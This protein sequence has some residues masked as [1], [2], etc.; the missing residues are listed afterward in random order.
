M[1]G[2]SGEE[3]T[4]PFRS[5]FRLSQ[6]SRGRRK[7]MKH[8]GR[9]D[10]GRMEDYERKRSRKKW[11]EV[12]GRGEMSLQTKHKGKEKLFEIFRH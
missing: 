4:V 11:K 12:K 1:E 5:G 6:R 9:G 8:T 10:L 7:R 2:H 3:V